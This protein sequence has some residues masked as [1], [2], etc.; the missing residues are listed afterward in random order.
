[1]EIIEE[2]FFSFTLTYLCYFL[3]CKTLRG[4]ERKSERI[5]IMSSKFMFIMYPFSLI[6][7]ILSKAD[8]TFRNSKRLS[9]PV[10]SVGNLT[11]GGTG[12]TPIVIEILNLLT[13]NNLKPAVLTRG[14]YRSNKVPLLL[15]NGG[16]GVDTSNSGDEPLL[17][18][19]SVPKTAVI[20]GVNR[21]K[22][23]LRF[24]SEVKPDIYVL[25]DGFQHWSIKRDLD[26]VCINAANPFGNGM[27]IPAGI[28]R[29]KP[30]AL[31]R[32]DIVIITNADMISDESLK[33]LKESVFILS[34]QEPVV[35]CYGNF[36]YKTVDLSTNFDAELLRKSSVYSLSA[37]GFAKGFKNSIEKS[38]IRVKGDI[39]LRDHIDYN[40]NMIKRIINRKDKNSFFI[41]TA[42]DAVKLKDI[43]CD[44][45]EKVVVL[46][47]EPQ[48]ETGREQWEQKILRH[49]QF[50]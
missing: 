46:V 44:I 19:R 32:A 37:V 39:I 33:K 31:K 49:L 28:L 30:E 2:D 34:G 10:I 22:N 21:Y 45:K 29:E 47:V 38:G 24:E 41:I 50:F 23:A 18:A 5:F 8:R 7:S 25:D 3:I 16:T 43:S 6:Y 1:M 15:S 13:N 48:F 42:K 26:V 14:Y 35:T 4:K 27:L 17:I 40:H 20:V 36:K 11:W 12:K 9:K